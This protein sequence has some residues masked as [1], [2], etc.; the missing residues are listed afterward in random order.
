MDLDLQTD[1]VFEVFVCVLAQST[2]KVIVPLRLWKY[3]LKLTSDQ[4]ISPLF[5]LLLPLFW[6]QRWWI[7]SVCEMPGRQRWR[8]KCVIYSLSRCDAPGL[9]WASVHCPAEHTS[10]SLENSLLSPAAPI[11]GQKTRNK[12]WKWV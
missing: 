10:R 2:Q 9:V 1:V 7:W 6:R 12:R 11:P 8:T 4:A 5:F 3:F